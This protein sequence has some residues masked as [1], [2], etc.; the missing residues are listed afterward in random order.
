M[1]DSLKNRFL[2]MVVSRTQPANFV[3]E[4]TPQIAYDLLTEILPFVQSSLPE[5]YEQA[6][7][8]QLQALRL[9]QHAAN[10]LP[11]LLH[12]PAPPQSHSEW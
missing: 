11:I 5:L 1:S 3:I 7:N 2:A 6:L 9:F 10:D 4:P 8:Q 12:R